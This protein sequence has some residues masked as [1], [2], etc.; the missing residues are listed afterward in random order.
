MKRF[1]AILLSCSLLVLSG[2]GEIKSPNAI[3]P[4]N[5]T[6]IE[7]WTYYNGAQ[8]EAFESLVNEF[9]Q[10]GKDKGMYVKHSSLG[11][12]NVLAEEVIRAVKGEVGA[13]DTPNLA[14]IYPE[15]AYALVGMDALVNLDE[16]FSEKD[17][18]KYIPSFLQEG[19]LTQDGFLY[20]FPV[21]KSTELLIINKTDWDKFAK[22]TGANSKKLETV[23]GITKTAE[24]YYTWT[25]LLTP[26]IPDDGKAFF[27][28]DA[29]DNYLYTGS[30]QLGQEFFSIEGD[31]VSVNLNKDILR[32]LW[33]NYYIPFINGY[34]AAEGKFRSD[35]AKTGTIIAYVG[36]SASV[37]YFPDKVTLPDDSSYPIEAMVLPAPYFKNATVKYNPQQGAG[38]SAIK[39]TAAENQVAAE[40][41][42]WFTSPEKNMGFSVGSSYLPVTIEAND[43]AKLT[44]V[45][46]EKASLE[47]DALLL[48]AEVVRNG[49]LYVAKPFFGAADARKILKSNLQ[50]VVQNAQKSIEDEESNG[51]SRKDS[52]RRLSS[53]ECFEEWY[54]IISQEIKK[55]I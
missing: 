33:D 19:R 15:T 44:A 36:S 2:C 45:F 35:D 25:D 26:E 10:M 8:Q 14:M 7:V 24:E 4:E 51:I 48:G 32:V 11:E 39:G 29:L 13:K 16:Y 30:A 47:K 53:D 9:N 55:V 27:G 41:L 28:R 34:F 31:T 17:L 37:Q 49:T 12:I 40:F 42:R 20:I 52:I 3:D 6:E 21:A 18:Q 54:A 38:F 22:E 5:P 1:L 50:T 46:G 43:K 23:E